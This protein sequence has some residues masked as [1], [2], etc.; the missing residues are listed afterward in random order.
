MRGS[1][2]RCGAGFGVETGRN[3]KSSREIDT[4]SYHRSLPQPLPSSTMHC[5]HTETLFTGRRPSARLSQ[6]RNQSQLVC[7]P[8]LRLSHAAHGRTKDHRYA[9]TKWSISNFADCRLPSSPRAQVC[10]CPPRAVFCVCRI[11][12]PPKLGRSRMVFV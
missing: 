2:P 1:S 7:L 10:F 5:K 12:G 9:L 11:T 4:S 6:S 3:E 8:L